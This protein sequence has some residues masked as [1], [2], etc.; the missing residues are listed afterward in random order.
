MLKQSETDIAIVT[1]TK[2]T[3]EKVTDAEA[4]IPG[5]TTPICCDQTAQGGGVAVWLKTGL[6]FQQLSQI[7]TLHF[8]M[9]WLSIS[10]RNKE[11]VVLCAVYR[12][13]SSP[14]DDVELPRHLDSS[15]DIARRHGARVIVAGDCNVHNQSWFNSTKTT[16]AGEY[17]EDI[18]NIHG[19][20][21][22]V[23]EPTR[24]NALLDLVLSDFPSNIISSCGAPLGASD[25]A[26]ITIDFPLHCLREP[27]TSR[28]VWR[29]SRADWDRLRHFFR[30]ADWSNVIT[31]N[32]DEPCHNTTSIIQEGMLKFI[33]SK[34]LC[35]RP[36]DPPWWTQSIFLTDAPQ[37]CFCCYSPKTS[38]DLMFSL[39]L[40]HK[41][42]RKFS[43]IDGRPHVLGIS[44]LY[45]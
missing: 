21:Q 44:F 17:L 28:T 12:S 11:K 30:T 33:S 36:S 5:Y 40:Q 43:S 13:G 10:L 1:E 14:G 8:D 27:R 39:L 29:Y 41:I 42:V 32:P 38:H 2:F 45:Y 18:A 34:Q 31:E 22:H 16:K 9:V 23:A 19:L 24:G 7:N 3:P 35:T 6:G 25:H 26:T 20:E 15:L 4:S 37:K